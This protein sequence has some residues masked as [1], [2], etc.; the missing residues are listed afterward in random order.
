MNMLT[1]S[2]ELGVYILNNCTTIRKTAMAFG[3]SKSTV[4]TDLSKKL[5]YEN[6][7]LFLRV[8]ALLD[9]NFRE[10]HIRGGEATKT[11]Y[12][13]RLIWAVF[14]FF[15]SW[16]LLRWQIIAFGV[17]DCSKN[18]V[19]NKWYLFLNFFNYI[20]GVFTLSV[21]VNRTFALNY[22]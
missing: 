3:L 15:I 5:K 11:K 6:Y 17:C 1:R 2:E 22:R 7:E 19:F 18:T 8:K 10:K 12:K 4:H 14:L 21:F 20:F 9:K 13:K 16:D